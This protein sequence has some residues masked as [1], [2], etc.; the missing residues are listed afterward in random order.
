MAMK[1]GADLREEKLISMHPNTKIWASS[2]MKSRFELVDGVWTKP[3]VDVGGV[4]FEGA[5][6]FMPP[7]PANW[8]AF[9]TDFWTFQANMMENLSEL[10]AQN[11]S[12]WLGKII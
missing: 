11:E 4:G 9:M 8:S 7:S 10:R 3:G 2:I 6:P 12:L 1:L 5:A